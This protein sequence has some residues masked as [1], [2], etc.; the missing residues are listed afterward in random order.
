MVMAA[1]ASADP[2]PPRAERMFSP[3]R[4]AAAEDSPESLVLNPAN[5]AF[6]PGAEAR[7]MG[8]RCN[9]TQKI[10]CGHALSG[11]TTIL[12]GLAAGFRGGHIPPPPP[13]P[14]VPPHPPF[15]GPLGRS[16]YTR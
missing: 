11:A 13:F 4:G 12:F 10:A 3:G 2:L 8:A 6:M 7:W 9:D 1:S 5:I 15:R 14:F 16:D